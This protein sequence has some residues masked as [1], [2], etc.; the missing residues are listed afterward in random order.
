M[1]KIGIICM[2]D[3]EVIAIKRK[4]HIREID[5]KRG[6]LFYKGTLDEKEVVLVRTTVGKVSAAICAQTLIDVYEVEFVISVGLAGALS[7]DLN[8]GD[9]VIAGETTRIEEVHALAKH[10]EQKL[11]IKHVNVGHIISDNQFL[12]SM[13]IKHKHTTQIAYCAEMEGIAIAHA[14]HLSEIPFVMMRCVS[15]K[16]DNSGEMNYED[17]AHLVAQRAIAFVEETL[18]NIK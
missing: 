7:P 4:M 12:E 5:E 13:E 8:I 1:K 3:D 6:M 9:L 18:C 16:A 14:C 10:I 15:D 17:F 2:I 11:E